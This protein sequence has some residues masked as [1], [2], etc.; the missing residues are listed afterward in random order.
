[1]SVESIANQVSI[2]FGARCEATKLS[3]I[4]QMGCWADGLWTFVFLLL[5]IFRV[6]VIN[7]LE[8]ETCP[9]F[10]I[11]FSVKAAGAWKSLQKRL[12]SGE[13]LAVHMRKEDQCSEKPTF[14]PCVYRWPVSLSNALS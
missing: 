13:T 1:M 14:Q 3:G 6:H 11:N 2:S 9:Q 4:G 5:T 12:R 10:K 7:Q 8:T